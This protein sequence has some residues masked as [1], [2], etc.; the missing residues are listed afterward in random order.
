MRR[1]LVKGSVT[2]MK[3]RYLLLGVS[4]LCLVPADAPAQRTT[5]GVTVEVRNVAALSKVTTYA[6]LPGQPSFDK[7]LDQQI[8]SAM[9]RELRTVGLTKAAQ[10][11]AADVNVSY[12]SQRRTD[13]DL[14]SKPDAAGALRQYPVGTLLVSIQEAAT[15]TR[16]FSARVV[17]PIE[18]DPAKL[19]VT[20]NAAVGAIFERYPRKGKPQ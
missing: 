2:S 8:V 12:F 1:V 19:E 20:V 16:I 6:Y 5:Y 10:G 18:L 11:S 17:E 13:V 3:N 15:K 9:E 7:T 4:L 14:K